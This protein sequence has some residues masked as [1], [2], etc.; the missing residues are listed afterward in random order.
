MYPQ[1]VSFPVWSRDEWWADD[2]DGRG[3]GRDVDFN[4]SMFDQIWE[5]W[6]K[7]PRAAVLHAQAENCTYSNG[8]FNSKNCYLI[9]GC[10]ETENA[11]YGHIVWNSKESFD[12]L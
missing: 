6:Q 12:N 2:W 8:V 1:K 11:A 5:L 4:R 3:F 10:V 9:F 7:V